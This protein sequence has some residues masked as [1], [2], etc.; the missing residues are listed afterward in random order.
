MYRESRYS[1]RIVGISSGGGHLTELLM[2]CRGL[3]EVRTIITEYGAVH[4]A[5][6][7]GITFLPIHDPHR[8]I[9]LFLK[10]WFQALRYLRSLKPDIVLSTGAGMTVP[11]FLMA[12]VL[13]ELCIFVETGARVTSPSLTGRILY[14]FSHL[15]IVQSEALLSVYPRAQIASIIVGSRSE[16]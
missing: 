9:P 2:V 3:P 1:M 14:P 12:R 16:Q 13:G 4:R 15:F 7:D 8:S 6:A 11:F 10:N 5:A